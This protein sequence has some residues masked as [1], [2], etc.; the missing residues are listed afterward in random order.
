MK[1]N[2]ALLFIPVLF[3]GLKSSGQIIE[4]KTKIKQDSVL[5]F[6]DCNLNE[7]ESEKIFTKSEVVADFPGGFRKW[8]DFAQTN[9][10]FDPVL[11]RMIDTVQE[12]KD[13]LVIKFIVTRRGE[14]CNIKIIKGDPILVAPT[15]KLLRSSPNWR[16]ASAGG[17]HINS[18]RTLKLELVIDKRLQSRTVRHTFTSYFRDNDW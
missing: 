15:I 6:P 13:S 7:D 14:I 4:E 8:F 10:D 16:P 5:R 1:I 12:Y 2:I 9:F 3:F 17:R 18:Y 11:E